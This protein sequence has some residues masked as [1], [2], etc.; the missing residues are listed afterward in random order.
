MSLENHKENC[1]ENRKEN[2]KQ[3]R[4]EDKY[5]KNSVDYSS[6]GYSKQNEVKIMSDEMDDE[7]NGSEEI[8]FSND[9]DCINLLE[10]EFFENLNP[11][12]HCK[13]LRDSNHLLKLNH[14][15]IEENPDELEM[16]GFFKYFTLR[17]IGIHD[18]IR[19]V[20]FEE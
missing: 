12:E 11:N 15:F 20:Y 10:D 1:K 9:E 8:D 16:L 4:N 18:F 13:N 14:P 7:I 2:K 19:E 5:V 17:D 6:Y 3:K